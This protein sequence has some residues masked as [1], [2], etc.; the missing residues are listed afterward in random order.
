MIKK[1]EWITNEINKNAYTLSPNGI[2]EKSFKKEWE[3][4]ETSNKNS[5]YFVC[6]K[7]DTKDIKKI[8]QVQNVNFKLIDTNLTFEFKKK[9]PAITTSLDYEDSIRFAEEKHESMICDMAFNNFK[10]SRF[11]LDPEINNSTANNLKRNWVKNYFAGNRGD[12][13][14]VSIQ[15]G[16][17]V[18]F[19]L[20]IFQSND[21]I[22]DLVCVKSNQ[23]R[24]GIA[25]KMINFVKDKFK[26]TTLKVGTQV[27]NIPSLRTYEKLGFKI[28]NT[29]YIFHY[30]NKTL[31]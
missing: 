13:M 14:I 30:H 18:G 4:F 6:S 2:D 19:L 29:N 28:F 23:R 5:K 25:S 21:L 24:S 12:S 22:I 10:Y 1:D 9:D 27:C 7:I 26:Y 8:S 11:H 15:D 17:L 31:K 16:A 3:R 20:L